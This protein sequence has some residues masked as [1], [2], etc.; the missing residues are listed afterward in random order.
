MLLN[1]KALIV[2]LVLASAMFALAKPILLRYSE[3]DAFRRR[4]NIWF[5]L[6]VL[7]FTSPSIWLYALVAMP[8][9]YWGAKKDDNPLALYL[10]LAY[11]IPRTNVQIPTIGIGQLL[12]LN[13]GRMMSFAILIPLIFRRVP[14]KGMVS[15]RRFSA[16][17][18]T[19][20]GF[21]V[22]QLALV[23]PYDSPTNSLRRGLIFFLDTFVMYYVFARIAPSA[24]V[25]REVI[26]YLI[27]AVALLSSF[28][29]F[30][31][32][33]GWL[34]F[35]GIGPQWGAIEPFTAYLMRGSLLRAQA[36]TGHSL[37]LGAVTATGLGLWFYLSTR[38]KRKTTK[39]AVFALLIGA[40]FVTG[41]RGA[42]LTAMIIFA[43]NSLLRPN[44]ARLLI[45]AVPVIIVALVVAYNSPLKESV[46]DRM[47]IIGT[48][49]QDTVAYRQEIAEVSWRLIK[50]N[51]VFGDPFALRN[52]EELRQGQGIIDLMNGYANVAVFTG[53]VGFALFVSIFIIVLWRTFSGMISLRST[54]LE[55]SLLGGNLIACLVGSLFF[56]GTAAIDPITYW[57]SGILASYCGL[58]I[59]QGQRLNDVNAQVKTARPAVAEM[60]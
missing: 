53:G 35:I 32:V 57:L 45:K 1:L 33:K 26:A 11:V 3:P 46:I 27:F 21:G 42:W 6:T 24:K 60:R 5:I 25:L 51:P 37:A 15:E 17:D 47:P 7:G 49:D 8:L 22:L 58:V 48:S 2:V 28:A 59:A 18:W 38:E 36:S 13:Q 19:L 34:L 43:L 20:F 9:M 44:A 31:A 4:R 29:I 30:E 23:L 14:I 55:L 39:Y 16:M 56:V 54:D 41:S 50:Q 12:E 40:C 10:L 52:M